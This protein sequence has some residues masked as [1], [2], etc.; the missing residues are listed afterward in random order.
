MFIS[1][2]VFV[3]VIS[4]A[5]HLPFYKDK[6]IDLIVFVFVISESIHVPFFKGKHIDLF[7]LWVRWNLE[8]MNLHNYDTFS[9]AQPPTIIIK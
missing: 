5:V 9:P 6:H 1:S 2:I 4:E 8:N 7:H 3:F